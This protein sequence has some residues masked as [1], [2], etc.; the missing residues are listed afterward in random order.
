MSTTKKTHSSA[1][2]E[3]YVIKGGTNKTTSQI[4][5]RPPAPPAQK[6]KQK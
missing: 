4:K 5:V 6:P 3:G 1:L 2:V